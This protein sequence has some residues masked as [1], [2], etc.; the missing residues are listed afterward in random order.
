MAGNA[1][2]P[3]PSQVLTTLLLCS[4]IVVAAADRQIIALL[5]PVLDQTFGWTA[6]DYASIAAWTQVAAAC[7]LLAAGWL[8]DWA[9]PKRTLG[10]ALTGWRLLTVL[11]AFASSLRDFV[12]IR[13][14]LGASE[15]AGT[16]SML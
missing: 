13:A 5:K 4:I 16:P 14:G 15:G 10:L 7:S 11:H 8:V 9:G 1:L 6:R 12:L 2:S 3:R